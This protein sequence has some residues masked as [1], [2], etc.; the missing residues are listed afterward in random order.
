MFKKKKI[1][2]I[3]DDK[4]LLKALNV[5][6]LGD[7]FEVFSAIDGCAGL[8]LILKEK[9][10]LILLDLVMPKLDGFA[11]LSALKNNKDTVHIPV[12]ILSNLTQDD[13]VKRG[14]ELG[15]KDYIKKTSTDLRELTKK[16]NHFLS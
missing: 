16:I 9:P 3:E 8:E 13:D 1:V 15:A 7:E 6:L 10:D 12:I 4:I 2:I 5:E 14:L 11:V